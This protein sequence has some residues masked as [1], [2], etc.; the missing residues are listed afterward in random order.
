MNTNRTSIHLI[1]FLAGT[2]ACNQVETV[3]PK[4]AS[5][6]DAVFASGQVISDHEYNVTANAEGYLTHQ[7]VDEGLLVKPGMPLFQLSNGVQSE[8]LSNAELNYRDALKKL[9]ENS[10]ERVQ[11]ELQIKQAKSQLELDKKNFERYEKLLATNAVSKLEYE[12]MKVQYE[13][14]LWNVDI[15]EKALADLIRALE[16][17]VENTESQVTIQQE[18]NLDYF[19]SSSIE[20]KCWKYTRSPGNW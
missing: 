3:Q 12:K 11:K 19:L 16:L 1:A 14:S 4:Q 9:N 18:N 2:I 5:I 17:N 6:V 15:H 20:G 7:Y 13:H 8:Q 10:P